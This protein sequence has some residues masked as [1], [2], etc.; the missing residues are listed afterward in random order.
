[1]ELNT[2]TLTHAAH[3]DQQAKLVLTTNDNPLE[4]LERTRL[5]PNWISRFEFRFREYRLTC[6]YRSVDPRDILHKLNMVRNLQCLANRP[7]GNRVVPGF[8]VAV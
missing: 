2:D 8:L 6:L 1:M 3:R 7:G 5:D 4:I